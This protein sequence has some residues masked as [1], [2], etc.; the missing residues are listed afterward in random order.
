MGLWTQVPAFAARTVGVR[1]KFLFD[2]RKLPYVLDHDVQGIQSHPI[3]LHGELRDAQY[4][5]HA[6]IRP[7]RLR[8]RVILYVLHHTIDLTDLIWHKERVE[9]STLP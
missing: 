2:K 8:S 9:E 4:R 6:A 5:G 3:P 7:P 1:L